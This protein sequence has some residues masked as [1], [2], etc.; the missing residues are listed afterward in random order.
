MFES[1]NKYLTGPKRISLPYSTEDL[2]LRA[3]SVFKAEQ[4][5]KATVIG[6]NLLLLKDVKGK[7]SVDEIS[8]GL[9]LGSVICSQYKPQTRFPP[10][11][12]I[13][14][15]KLYHFTGSAVYRR[16]D[17]ES[18]SFSE[19]F[20]P[21]QLAYFTTNQAL[22]G[23]SICRSEPANG[24][25]GAGFV[26]LLHQQASSLSIEGAFQAQ[27]GALVYGLLKFRLENYPFL[28]TLQ[29]DQLKLRVFP[30]TYLFELHP[31][32]DCG[33]VCVTDELRKYNRGEGE[34]YD[35]IGMFNYNLSRVDI[36]DIPEGCLSRYWVL[37]AASYVGS[38]SQIFIPFFEPTEN[39]DFLVFDNSQVLDFGVRFGRAAETVGLRVVREVQGSKFI[40]V[41][42]SKKPASIKN[43]AIK[44]LRFFKIGERPILFVGYETHFRVSSGALDAIIQLPNAYS[45]AYYSVL[46]HYVLENPM[47]DKCVY[48]P[49]LLTGQ[50]EL[51]CLKIF[52]V[53][54]NGGYLTIFAAD[55]ERE[56]GLPIFWAVNKKNQHIIVSRNG[57]GVRVLTANLH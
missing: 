22:P 7:F 36:V 25:L 8:L 54:L 56:W 26:K 11:Y 43:Q 40:L 41:E 17:L 18:S 27:G 46:G 31:L 33:I 16:V 47:L 2:T 52:E 13:D 9:D 50:G 53:N 42:D 10:G 49:V 15:N 14:G 30:D 35:F 57:S 4:N 37:D 12:L 5:T 48:I 6:N 21:L 19:D 45:Q 24:E 44:A 34:K 3:L 38:G 23:L 20:T 1:S 29:E 55:F 51:R 32:E 28:G 39:A